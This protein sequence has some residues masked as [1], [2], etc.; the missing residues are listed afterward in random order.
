[1]AAKHPPDQNGG[2]AS[3][4]EENPNDADEMK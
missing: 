3:I 2:K 1:M 4:G